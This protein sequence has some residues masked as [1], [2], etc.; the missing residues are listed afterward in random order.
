VECREESGVVYYFHLTVIALLRREGGIGTEDDENE[1]LEGRLCRVGR[2]KHHYERE[3]MEHLGRSR[4]HSSS[5]GTAGTHS[6]FLLLW[7]THIIYAKLSV[8]TLICNNPD[9]IIYHMC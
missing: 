9:L 3:Q 2:K 7:C 1:N 4:E 6:T 8:P 5:T